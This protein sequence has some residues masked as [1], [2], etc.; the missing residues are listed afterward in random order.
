MGISGSILAGLTGGFGSGYLRGREQRR[1]WE[2]EDEQNRLA[3]ESRQ[4]NFALQQSQLD[5]LMQQMAMQQQQFDATNALGR[6]RLGLDRERFAASQVPKPILPEW[7]EE[8]FTDEATYLDYLGRRSAAT[9]APE[10]PRNIDPLSPEGIAARL[11]F[12]REKPVTGTASQG[13][14][15]PTG[16]L[17]KLSLLR[18]VAGEA[19]SIPAKVMSGQGNQTGPVVG[20]LPNWARNVF[21]PGSTDS[22]QQIAFV[23]S[24]YRNLISGQAVSRS[25]G[26]A[27]APLVPEGTDPEEIA[28]QK[29]RGFADL[30]QKILRQRESDL[31]RAGYRVDGDDPLENAI[32]EDA[33]TEV[34]DDRDLIRR[35]MRGGQ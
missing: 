25:E 7:Q 5:R 11:R 10:S 32:G 16:T 34:V 27:L 33:A 6:D 18:T 29:A 15:V 22:Q 26:E 28:A 24:L 20:H 14:A 19:A 1:S 13:R 4:R 8:G 21:V 30:L 12:E 2:T 23:R 35:A 9:R 17:E 3:E 31:R